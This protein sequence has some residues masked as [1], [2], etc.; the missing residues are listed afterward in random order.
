M[1]E[2]AIKVELSEEDRKILLA[3]KKILGDVLKPEKKNKGLG[4]L[5]AE[6]ILSG[7]KTSITGA[8]WVQQ[9][10]KKLQSLS[11]KKQNNS[12]KNLIR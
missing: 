5:A 2:K 9:P 11:K 4:A 8:H 10:N 3:Q 1:A 6:L 7:K 12:K